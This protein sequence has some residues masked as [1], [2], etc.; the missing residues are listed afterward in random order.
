MRLNQI[1]GVL[2]VVACLSFAS[3]AMADGAC[4]ADI[5]KIQCAVIPAANCTGSN[6]T[7]HEGMG[8]EVCGFGAEAQRCCEPA[9]FNGIDVQCR[10]ADDKMCVGD[11]DGPGTV[12]TPSNECAASVPTVSELGMIAT[13]L[14]ML[15]AGTLVLRR[16]I[17]RAAA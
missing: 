12:C 13:A 8:C 17:P 15:G 1:V 7:H 10:L 16:R 4:C 5:G 3:S 11:L 2:A 14:V 6:E 9:L